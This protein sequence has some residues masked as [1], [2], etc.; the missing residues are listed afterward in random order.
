MAVVKEDQE[1]KNYDL[2]DYY[3]KDSNTPK[4]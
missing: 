4:F 1:L 3:Y 2:C